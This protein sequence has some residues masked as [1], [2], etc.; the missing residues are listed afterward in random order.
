[1]LEQFQAILPSFLPK[2]PNCSVT[3]FAQPVKWY[4]PSGLP[5]K[6]TFGLE[7]RGCTREVRVMVRVSKGERRARE[8]DSEGEVSHCFS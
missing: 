7:G 6:G 5:K 8:R 2:A 3:V 1:M 4:L